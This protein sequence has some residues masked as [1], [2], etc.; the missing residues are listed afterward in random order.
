[1]NRSRV[2]PALILIAISLALTGVS[3]WLVADAAAQ[4][5]AALRGGV[6]MV[7]VSGGDAVMLLLI[8][9]FVALG[10]WA[11]HA[12]FEQGDSASDKW[13][14][15][16]IQ[17]AVV[18][19]ALGLIAPWVYVPAVSNALAA[20]NYVRCPDDRRPARFPQRTYARS[21]ADCPAPIS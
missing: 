10:V 20:R 19:I 12:L 15:R 7:R 13:S 14:G 5:L 1:M 2:G 18:V 8:P 9:V 16:L 21:T 3:T 4:V 6:S 17:G 11:L